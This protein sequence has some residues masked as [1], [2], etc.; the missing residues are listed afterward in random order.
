MELKRIS[1]F[2]SLSCSAWIESYQRESARESHKLDAEG[3][4]KLTPILHE[5]YRRRC[6]LR[7][8][9]IFI[10]IFLSEYI[11]LKNLY[12]LLYTN[13]AMYLVDFPNCYLIAEISWRV[14]ILVRQPRASSDTLT[15]IESKLIARTQTIRYSLANIIDLLWDRNVL[16]CSLSQCL[17]LACGTA[18]Y[19]AFNHRI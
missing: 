14:T 12:I 9:L 4:V 13:K 5:A 18:S 8:F 1:L 11:Y 10:Y 19:S 7:V 15:A 3:Q 16:T 17:E 2:L 6:C